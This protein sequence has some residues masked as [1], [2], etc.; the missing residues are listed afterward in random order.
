MS[1]STLPLPPSFESLSLS[2]PEAGH[3]VK[4]AQNHKGLEREGR[5]DE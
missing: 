4:E 1:S 2:P 5:K 3:R